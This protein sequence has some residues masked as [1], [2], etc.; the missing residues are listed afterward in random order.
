M[1]RATPSDRMRPDS[2]RGPTASPRRRAPQRERRDRAVS[3]APPVGALGRYLGRVDLRPWRGDTGDAKAVAAVHEA[4]ARAA[5]AHIFPP[6]GAFPRAETRRR[7]RT[8]SGRVVV[9]EDAGRVVDSRRSTSGSCTP[10]TSCPPA[11]AAAWVGGCWR[12]PGQCGSCGCCATTPA[13]GA[14][15]SATDG[16][17]TG[18]RRRRPGPWSCGTAGQRAERPR[19]PPARHTPGG[20]SHGPS[21]MS[22]GWSSGG[23]TRAEFRRRNLGR[24]PALGPV[25]RTPYLVNLTLTSQR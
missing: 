3:P 13:P 2:A 1:P 7:W 5:Y 19:G 22:A 10:S 9:A 25:G 24:P 16:D 11:G 14:S 4:A 8:F 15:T 12:R 21:R 17:P 23:R 18:R 6:G 20:A